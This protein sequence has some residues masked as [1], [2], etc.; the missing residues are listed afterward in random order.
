[1]HG[2]KWQSHK[3][4]L[5]RYKTS[6]IWTKTFLFSAKAMKRERQAPESHAPATWL[7]ENISKVAIVALGWPDGAF[8]G[9]SGFPNSRAIH[10]WL[11]Y[12][13]VVTVQRPLK[14]KK[15]T[16]QLWMILPKPHVTHKCIKSLEGTKWLLMLRKKNNF[17][18][19]VLIKAVIKTFERGYQ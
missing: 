1:M 3:T 13:C 19:K 12:I 5:L 14:E 6:S 11:F 2:R 17:L 10:I 16:K 8:E 15:D 4:E 9:D 7:P 18:L